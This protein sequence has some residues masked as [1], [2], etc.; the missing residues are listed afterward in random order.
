MA[1]ALG[2]PLAALN[3]FDF[4]LNT[5]STAADELTGKTARERALRSRADIA[6]ALAN[7]AAAQSALQLEIARQYPDVHL[8][9]GYQW[10]QGEGKWQLGLTL[11]I[12][13]LNRNQGPIAEAEARRSSFRRGASAR[14]QQD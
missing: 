9:T 6:A 12:P 10:D 4:T 7:Y 1:E 11:E 5:D 13:V 14:D 8:G 3:H 2:V